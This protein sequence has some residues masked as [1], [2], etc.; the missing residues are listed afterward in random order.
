M[1]E[2]NRVVKPSYLTDEKISELTA[3]FKASGKSVWNNE[4]IKK[5][6]L[7]SSHGKCAYCECDLRKE[8]NYMEV[9]HFEDKNHNPDK[10]VIWN[11]L[12]PSCK[13]CNGAK[14]AHDVI[15]EPIIRFLIWI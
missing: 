15:S 7:E 6:L 1:I 2:L 5:P 8:S 9:E 10:V 4:Q 11:N 13:K 3:E 12:L 14:G